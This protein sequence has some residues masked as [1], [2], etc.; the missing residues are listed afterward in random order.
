MDTVYLFRQLPN[1]VCD[2]SNPLNLR[3]EDKALFPFIYSFFQPFL[4]I[5]RQSICF[6]FFLP[7]ATPFKPRNRNKHSVIAGWNFNYLF[8]PLLNVF[9]LMIHLESLLNKSLMQRV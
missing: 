5:S 1:H 4:N 2:R 6:H 7:I 3:D 8:F 9:F